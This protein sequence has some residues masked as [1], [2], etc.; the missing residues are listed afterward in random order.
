MPERILR[1]RNAN[2]MPTRKKS[3]STKT[4]CPPTN[5]IRDGSRQKRVADKADVTQLAER[6]SDAY[7][8]VVLLV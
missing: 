5:G 1:N 2:K 6:M 8:D 4:V 3:L 7:G